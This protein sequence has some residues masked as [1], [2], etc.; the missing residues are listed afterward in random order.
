[1][2]VL[3]KYLFSRSYQYN[4]Q[5]VKHQQ[6][7]DLFSTP[8]NQIIGYLVGNGKTCRCNSRS[9][10]KPQL[11]TNEPS[12]GHTVTTERYFRPSCTPTDRKS[13]TQKGRPQNGACWEKEKGYKKRWQKEEG[14]FR[15]FPI[16]PANSKPPAGPASD[17]C[18]AVCSHQI[19]HARPSS[20]R[21]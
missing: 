10:I 4:T 1:M 18:A 14:T 15:S 11:N 3:G 17:M 12:V 19:V 8:Q 9:S 5:K 21:I 16:R 13:H 6:G 20:P 2:Q 7:L